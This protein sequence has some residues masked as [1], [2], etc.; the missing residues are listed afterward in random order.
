MIYNEWKKTRSSNFK[1]SE[2]KRQEKRLG[3]LFSQVVN[4]Q[5]EEK[6]IWNTDTI[7]ITGHRHQHE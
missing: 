4:N 2:E 5:N 7:D 6:R 3:F 1:Y